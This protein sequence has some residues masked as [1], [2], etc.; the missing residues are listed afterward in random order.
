MHRQAITTPWHGPKQASSSP[1]FGKGEHGR[2]G[3]GAS[4]A[5]E[6]V[7]KLVEALVGKKVVGASAGKET[8]AVWTEEGELLTCG[9]GKRGMLGHGGQTNEL[10]PRLVEAL[11]GKKVVGASAAP[12]CTAVWTEEGELFT[13][14]NRGGQLGHRGPFSTELVPKLVEALVGKKVVGTSMSQHHTLAWTEDGELFTFGMGEKGQL[15][16]GGEANELVPRLVEAL[17][18]KKVVSASAAHRHTVVATALGEVFTFGYSDKGGL[19]LG[20]GI[21]ATATFI[22]TPMLVQALAVK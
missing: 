21:A 10:V 6:L 7:P 15:G 20:Q 17:A 22:A 14:G 3:H 8:T 4:Q 18:G 11:V 19:G 16:H 5:N 1:T 13:F 2:L 9:N 12:A